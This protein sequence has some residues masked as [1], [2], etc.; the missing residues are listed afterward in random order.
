M[1]QGVTEVSF[2]IRHDAPVPLTFFTR[3]TSQ[4]NFPGAVALNF[5]PVLPNTWTTITI[6]ITPMNPQF[7]TF[8]GSDF[9]TVFGQ[10]QA[11]QFGVDVPLP[12][13]GLDQAFNFDIDNFAMMPAPSAAVMLL[14]GLMVRGRRRRS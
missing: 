12:L 10:V 2:D 4:N 7:I 14:A 9:A 8:E 5:I 3:F 13:A 6:A 11:I 1:A